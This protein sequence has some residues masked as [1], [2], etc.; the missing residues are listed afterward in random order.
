MKQE[1]ALLVLATFVGFSPAA[2][3][4]TPLPVVTVDGS[5]IELRGVSVARDDRGVYAA[6]WVRRRVGNYG[7]VNAHLHVDALGADG[8]T[9]QTIEARWIGTLPTSIRSRHASIFRARFE[10]AISAS[11]VSVRV[12]AEPGPRHPVE[13]ER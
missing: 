12:S 9:L 8:Q 2:Q 4:R 1:L 7:S 10:P 6:G 5:D 13:S 3:A 11:L